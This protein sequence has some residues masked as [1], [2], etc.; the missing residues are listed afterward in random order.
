MNP[1]LHFKLMNDIL[2][3]KSIQLHTNSDV[4]IACLIAMFL[5]LMSQTVEHYFN[6]YRKRKIANISP[7]SFRININKNLYNAT[8]S[9]DEISVESI[10]TT[11]IKA[12]VLDMSVIPV[13]TRL[14]L[15]M[16]YMLGTFD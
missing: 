11:H 14:M 12:S 8:T 15:T 9:T 6:K 2:F 1:F 13:E 7:E 3:V 16:F 10:D 5:P 4:F